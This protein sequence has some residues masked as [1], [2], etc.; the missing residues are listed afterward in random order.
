MRAYTPNTS[1]GRH[2]S[3]HDIHHKTSDQPKP[4]AK[5]TAKSMRHAAR[6]EGRKQVM[7]DIIGL[8]KSLFL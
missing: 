5:A 2:L 3:G 4:A 1:K 7:L 6:Q 8:G